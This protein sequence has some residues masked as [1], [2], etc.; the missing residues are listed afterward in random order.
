VPD[1]N[2]SAVSVERDVVPPATQ[3]TLSAGSSLPQILPTPPVPPLPAPSATAP[4]VA[5]GTTCEGG[6]P[7]VGL[8]IVPLS[9]VVRSN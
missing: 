8:P 7:I 5:A 3:A 2:S 4:E 6:L 9:V 1:A